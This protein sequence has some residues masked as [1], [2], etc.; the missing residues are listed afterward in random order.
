MSASNL[1]AFI[2]WQ[3]GSPVNKV[4]SNKM[5]V[6]HNVLSYNN[7]ALRYIEHVTQIYQSGS[8]DTA[9]SAVRC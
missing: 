1:V 7:A 2:I 4:K 8:S 5:Y 9:M 3:V 6:A